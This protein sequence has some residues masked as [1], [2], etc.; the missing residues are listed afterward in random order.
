MNLEQFFELLNKFGMPIVFSGIFLVILYKLGVRILNNYDARES[1]YIKVLDDSLSKLSAALKSVSDTC[2]S[3]H[4]ADVMMNER[5]SKDIKDG[6]DS[7]K[8]MGR[9]QREEH[10]DILNAIK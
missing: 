1:R 4:S 9:Y 8:E 2:A 5:I 7:M 6:F 3:S 10:K